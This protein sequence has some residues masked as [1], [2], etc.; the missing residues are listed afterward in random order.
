MASAGETRA[1][2]KANERQGDA[3]AGEAQRQFSRSEDTVLL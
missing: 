2:T 3:W 1:V